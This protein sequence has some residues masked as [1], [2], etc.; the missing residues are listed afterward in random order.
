MGVHALLQICDHDLELT[1]P[2]RR[3]I[4]T[5]TF[6][7]LLGHYHLLET[8]IFLAEARDLMLG[9]APTWC[10]R[11]AC[12]FE[13]ISEAGNGA[14]EHF[15]RRCVLEAQGQGV[16]YTVELN[17][18]RKNEIAFVVGFERGGG[19]CWLACLAVLK[20]LQVRKGKEVHEDGL[21]LPRQCR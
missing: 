13:L 8:Q 6:L 16:V 20:H 10:A 2:L 4:V 11:V 7:S 17:H 1:L 9:G 15:R 18:I 14:S 21:G 3:G 5:T 12:D 19:G